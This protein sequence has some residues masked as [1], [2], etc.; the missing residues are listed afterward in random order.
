MFKGETIRRTVMTIRAVTCFIVQ[1]GRVLLQKRPAGKIWAGMLNGPG[2]KVNAGEDAAEAIVRE[3]MEETGLQIISPQ[4]RGCL[5]LNIPSPKM[6][7]L[8][9]DIFT[10]HVFQ[11]DASD[12]E[13]SLSWHDRNAL[14][15]ESMW[16]DQRYWLHAVLDGLS[17]EGD[18]SYEPESLR[19]TQC[20][21]QLHLPVPI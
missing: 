5:T 11:G 2:G 8:S 7:K 20:Q 12:R 3:V 18:V 9:V 1:S 16:A 13:G 19:L 4:P 10:A 14:P 15:F 21:L 6:L 17:V